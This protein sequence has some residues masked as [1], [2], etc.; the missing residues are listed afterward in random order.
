MTIHR[1]LLKTTPLLRIPIKRALRL[2]LVGVED[3][4]LTAVMVDLIEQVKE[5]TRYGT[6]GWICEVVEVE[7]RE[8]R[9][10]G[11]TDL[12]D[13]LYYAADE[14]FNALQVLSDS[15]A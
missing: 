13:K 8:A 6:L 14:V 11:K 12:A 9:A 7:A 4:R 2:V 5:G 15:N 10:L 3:E 1:D